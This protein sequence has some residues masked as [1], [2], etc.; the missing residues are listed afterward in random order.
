VGRRGAPGLAAIDRFTRTEIAGVA[1]P[2]A[3]AAVRFDPLG[4]W[5][6]AAPA[7]GDTA[8]VVDLPTKRLVGG[9]PTAWAADLPALAPDGSL[10]V[11]QAA[12]V[13]ALT[14]DSLTERGRAAGGAADRWILSAWRPRG[15]P[16]PVAVAVAE[17]INTEG[18]LYVQVSVS[19]NAA[20]AEE[21][22]LQITRA[23]LPARVLPPESIEDGYRV[24]LGPYRTRGEAEAIGRKLGRPFWIYQPGVT[25]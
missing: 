11:R 2:G 19:Q 15:M 6:L 25:P 17:S 8:W 20:W 24:V 10:I 12:D 18:P 13:V 7:Q 3:A 16:A 22:A 1:L 14:P 9:V 23:G 21:N 4:R 5:L